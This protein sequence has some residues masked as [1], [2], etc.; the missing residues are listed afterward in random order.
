[1][2]KVLIVLLVVLV[3]IQFFQI[4]KTN[5]VTD[6]NQDFLKIHETPTEIAATIKATCYD[7][8]SNQSVYP[9]YTNVQPVGWFVKNHIEDGKKHLNFSE[10]GTYTAKKQAHKLEECYEL[11]EKGEMPLSSYTIIHKEAVL[12]ETQQTALVNYFKEMELKINK[13][14]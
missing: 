14:Q 4:D 6:I 11:I 10:F 5:P 7:C 8:H 12:T 2:K 13:V 3:V 1:M 9:W